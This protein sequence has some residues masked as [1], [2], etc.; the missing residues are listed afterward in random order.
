MPPELLRSAEAGALTPSAALV[1]ESCAVVSGSSPRATAKTAQPV[2]V[3]GAPLGVA[4][5]VK[6]IVAPAEEAVASASVPSDVMLQ[7]LTPPPLM[8]EMPA[9]QK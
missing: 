6:V 3:P 5:T 9:H 4:V 1:L 7:L 2:V 8:P